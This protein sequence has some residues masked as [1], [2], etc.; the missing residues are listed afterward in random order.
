MLHHKDNYFASFVGKMR[1]VMMMM[2][3]DEWSWMFGF[4]CVK[5]CCGISKKLSSYAS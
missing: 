4:G 1:R 3:D 5:I 2:C